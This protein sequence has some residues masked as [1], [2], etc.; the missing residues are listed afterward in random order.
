MYSRH[1]EG[2]SV[3]AERFVTMLKSEIQKYMIWISKK[4]FLLK[5]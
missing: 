1:N 4:M 5:N 2:E 3:V